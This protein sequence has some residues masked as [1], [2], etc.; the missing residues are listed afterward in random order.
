MP[1]NRPMPKIN[2]NFLNYKTPESF[3]VYDL[4]RANLIYPDLILSNQKV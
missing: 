2:G 3:Y 1:N 4:I